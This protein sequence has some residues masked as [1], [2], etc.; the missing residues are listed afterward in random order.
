MV[1][2]PTPLLTVTIEQRADR[3]DVHLHAG[4]Q[5][6]WQAR[7]VTSLGVPVVMCAAIGGEVGHVLRPLLER[8]GV[9]L[10]LVETESSTGAYV[11]DRRGGDRVTVAEMPTAPLSRH[12]L[13]E[14]YGVALAEGINA[15]VCVLSGPANPDAVSPDLYRRFVTDIDRNGGQV[16]AD[17]SGEHLTA[18]VEAGGVRLLK[19]SHEELMDSDIAG[20][21]NVPELVRAMFE[22]HERGAEAVVVTRAA[23]PALA[24][25]DEH[26]Y[27]VVPPKLE[28][29]DHRGAGDSMTAG[30]AAVLAQGGDLATAVRTGAAAGALNVTQHGLGTGAPGAIAKLIR[31]IE[32]VPVRTAPQPV[33]ATSPDELAGKAKQ[34]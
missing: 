26:V 2:A 32:L 21:D 7:M 12:E 20:D 30:V 28:P 22:L 13:D 23:E 10:R 33:S 3:P 25:V 34:R 16:V 8:E 11:H 29:A 19:V 9:E 18:A 14:L 31:H 4:G 24:L 27:Q 1:F 17:L 6:V 5:G 15:P